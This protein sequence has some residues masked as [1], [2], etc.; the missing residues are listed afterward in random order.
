MRYILLSFKCPSK[1][2]T[3]VVGNGIVHLS[4]N[5]L[6]IVDLDHFS[7]ERSVRYPFQYLSQLF[8]NTYPIVILIL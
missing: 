6:D 2:H 5:L 7:W 1:S 4:C 3:Y 8:A